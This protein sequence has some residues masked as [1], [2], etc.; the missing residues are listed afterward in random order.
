MQREKLKKDSK[1]EPAIC[2][3]CRTILIGA[4]EPGDTDY[5]MEAD[6]DVTL[7]PVNIHPISHEPSHIDAPWAFAPKHLEVSNAIKRYRE[8][9]RTPPVALPPEKEG[10]IV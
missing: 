8:N 5:C 6:R 7:R 1:Y 4:R 2:P 9:K 10:V 3:G